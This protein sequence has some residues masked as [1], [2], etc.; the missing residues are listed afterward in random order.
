MVAGLLLPAAVG[1][2]VTQDWMGAA[3]GFLWGGWVRL[4]VITHATGAVNSICHFF[5]SRPFE[6]RDC[7]GNVPWLVPFTLGESWH[8]NHHAFPTSARHGLRWW[9]LDP[10]WVVIWILEKLGL[11]RNVVRIPVER[12]NQKLAQ[13]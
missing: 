9:Q 11:A 12:Q 4:F 7:S 10:S 1:W 8:H 6:A 2:L 5:G 13:V 3:T